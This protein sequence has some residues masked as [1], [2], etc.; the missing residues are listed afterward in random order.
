MLKPLLKPLCLGVLC[1][2]VS[3]L[4]L[5]AEEKNKPTDAKPPSAEFRKLDRNS[6]G[7]L[8][9]EELSEILGKTAARALI[10]ALDKNGD[11]LLTAK[12]FDQGHGNGYAGDFKGTVK[13]PS[14]GEVEEADA[15]GK[16][17]VTVDPYTA[18][19]GYQLIERSYSAIT[20]T[21]HQDAPSST[22]ATPIS[23]QFGSLLYG[24]IPAAVT[25]NT[26]SEVNAAENWLYVFSHVVIRNMMTGQDTPYNGNVEIVCYIH[27]SDTP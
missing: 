13:D 12:E 3:F 4:L 22:G 15:S 9:E 24:N 8:S 25:G 17:K 19:S 21:T 11:G 5:S 27:K 14:D 26:L 7:R 2:P 23:T 20:Y 16:F 10:R 18:P 6:D 1:V